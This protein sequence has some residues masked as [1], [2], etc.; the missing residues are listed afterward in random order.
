MAL[1]VQ[2]TVHLSSS[3]LG[4]NLPHDL[5]GSKVDSVCC[6]RNQRT[7]KSYSVKSSLLRRECGASRYKAVVAKAFPGLEAYGDSM[8]SVSP[9]ASQAAPPRSA[10]ADVM[11]LLLRQRIIFLGSQMDDY[12]ADAIVSQLLLL[13]AQDG[14][15]D[16]RLFINSPG[17]SMSSAMAIFD[18]IQLCRAD[19][20]T[21]AFGLAASTAAV[22]LAGGT[23]GKRF[24]MPNARI[25]MHQPLGG[26]S[27]QAI[28]VEIQA[29]EIMHHKENI[30]RI[31]S[32]ITGRPHQQVLK[33]IDRDRYMSPMEAAEYGMIDG[34][35]DADTVLEKQPVPPKVLSRREEFQDVRKFLT[36]NIPDSE[37]V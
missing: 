36:P 21:I 12:V 7:T 17:G 32:T 23:K 31:L 24:A 9:Y 8:A 33:D 10:E 22:V 25:M 29:K 5:H 18:A 3:F 11:G 1:S 15:Q 37:I 27:G 14:N 4:T 16:I 2:A 28:D 20:S 35:I 19:V 13:D 30:T 26:A 34:V 6:L